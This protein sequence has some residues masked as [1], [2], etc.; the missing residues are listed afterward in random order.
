MILVEFDDFVVGF[1]ILNPSCPAN[2][3]KQI[4]T[5]QLQYD[6][7][8]PVTKVIGEFKYWER[9]CI[10]WEAYLRCGKPGISGRR[11][12]INFLSPTVGKQTAFL[13]SF[14]QAA[15]VT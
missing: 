11:Q 3:L 1:F 10:T 7:E 5:Y 4:T 15:Y 2:C 13:L 8:R 6:L 14:E 12:Q 9:I